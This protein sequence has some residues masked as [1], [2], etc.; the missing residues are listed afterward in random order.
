MRNIIFAATL[1]LIA[2]PALANRE[3]RHPF[4]QAIPADGIHRVVIDIPAGDV[5]VHNS[6]GPS[7]AI[8]GYAKREYDGT[9]PREKH[10]K[11]VDDV[12]AEFHVSNE[13][14]VVRR[15]FGPNAR[16]WRAN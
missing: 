6:A 1:L 5:I 3:V 9:D 16:G 14:A 11:I 2:A 7:L 10:Q 4:Q 15:R 13:E 12:S 8:K